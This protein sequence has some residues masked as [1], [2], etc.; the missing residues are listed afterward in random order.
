MRQEF[1]VVF[2]GAGPVGTVAASLLAARRV[3]APARIA[4]IDPRFAREGDGADWDLRVFALNHASRRLLRAA[5][6]WQRLPRERISPYEH[7]CVWDASGEPGGRRSLSFDCA[8]LGEP[9]L[10]CI[11]DGRSLKWHALQAAREAGIT[12]IEAGVR[13]ITVDEG[14][15]R[16]RLDDGRDLGARLIAAADGAQS[17]VRELL[18][19]RTSGHDYGE[20]ALVFHVRTQSEHRRTAWQRFLASGPLAFLPLADGRS[21]IVWSVCHR[22]AAR[23]RSLE[24]GALAAALD[25]AS[26]GVLGRTQVASAIAAFPLR[27]RTA[28]CLAGERFALLGDAAHVVHP[29]AGQ[30]LNLGLMDCAAFVEVLEDAGGAAAFGDLR[31]L[32]RY[33]RWRRSEI[34]PSSAA[35]DGLDRLFSNADSRLSTLRGAGLEVVGSIGPLRRW[36]AARA[37]GTSGDLPRMLR[38]RG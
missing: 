22:E 17:P 19:V 6:V 1:D 25:E 4:V 28:E 36:F 7:M 18:G 27:L 13:A 12:M 34:G 24:P 33:E 16:V 9:D 26:A 37:L 15:V 30:G 29:L 11:V 2:A 5:G 23:L 32:R 38:G 8:E 31:V 20:D 3:S 10:G 35:F 14:A 21:S